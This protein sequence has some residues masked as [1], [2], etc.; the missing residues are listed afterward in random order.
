MGQKVHPYGFRLGFTKTWSAKWFAKGQYADNLHEDLMIRKTIKKRLFHAGISRIEIERYP[1]KVRVNI[2]AARPGIIIGRKGTEVEKLKSYFVKKTGK[3][4]HINI[5]EIKKPD[6]DAQLLAENIAQQLQRR[7]SFRRALKKA[8]QA[9]MQAGAK[10]VKVEI[11]G[12]LGGAEMSRREWYR[13]G[14]V[15]LHTLRADIDYSF[16]I[17]QTTSGV[18]G[19]KS[20]IFKGE[21]SGPE[22]TE[23]QQEV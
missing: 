14:R 22:S 2:H 11:S 23:A 16:A 8:Q 21:V 15:P 17:A 12:R 7:M 6:L 18:I 10:G 5:I 20:W 9:S 3:T 1:R 4:I 13:E 19:V